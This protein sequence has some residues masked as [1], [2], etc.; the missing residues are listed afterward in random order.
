MAVHIDPQLFDRLRSCAVG[1]AVGDALGM[2]LE[3]GA[4]SPPDALV[5]Q[6]LPGR[7]P[8][9]SFTDDTEMAIALAESLAAH[10]PLNAEDLA[11]RFVQWHECSPP[12]EG[13]QT[14]RALGWLARG[15]NWETVKERLVEEMPDSAGNGS[16]MRCW[17]VALA[18]W[19]N[20]SQRITDSKLQS[21]LTHPNPDCVSSCVFVNLLINDLARGTKPEQAFRASLESVSFPDDFRK[22]LLA[23]PNRTRE[24]LKNTGWVRHTL[25]SSIWALLTT[26]NFEEAVI[27]VVNLG[28]DADT[29]GAVTGAL[30]GAA[31]G[32]EAIPTSWRQQLK[33]IWPLSSGNTW[34]CQDIIALADKLILGT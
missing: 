14:A 26:E 11:Q 30:A 24:E 6:M 10:R 13:I 9:G 16:V 27:Q 12:D 15:E 32:L 31:Y 23:A 21:E 33:G 25:E 5:R 8:S 22:L 3:F 7:L 17:P 34:G 19:N 28:K 4:A 1:A 29:A 20:R 18:W 2:P